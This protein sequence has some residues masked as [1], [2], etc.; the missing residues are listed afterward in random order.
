MQPRKEMGTMWTKK[1]RLTMYILIMC[2]HC[3]VNH[4]YI[5]IH[6]FI[7]TYNVRVC[8]CIYVCIYTWTNA[9]QSHMDILED[10][11]SL[12]ILIECEQISAYSWLGSSKKGA[13]APS[14]TA[15]RKVSNRS[16]GGMSSG[17]SKFTSNDYFHECVGWSNSNFGDPSCWIFL[18]TSF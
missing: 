2:G 12:L 7:H 13:M 8:V 15:A 3:K 5:Y 16:W 11:H 17:R 6:M 1:R 10:H 4:V 18:K 9:E 14:E